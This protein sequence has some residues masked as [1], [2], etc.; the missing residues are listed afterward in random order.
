[1][2]NVRFPPIAVVRDFRLQQPFA[3]S[4]GRMRVV[5]LALIV[6]FASSPTSA[7]EEPTGSFACLYVGSWG[8]G[9]PPGGICVD[10][11]GRPQPNRSTL[12]VNFDSKPFPRIRLNGLDGHL[13]YNS[14]G[15]AFIYWHLGGLGHPKFSTSFAE[16]GTLTATFISTHP[17]GGYDS[18]NFT[19]ARAPKPVL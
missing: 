11:G 18:S 3:V 19:C 15:E 13:N 6:A 5:I 2:L 9:A 4:T 8:C 17:N 7:A 12:Q 1:M 10:S 16:N 14:D